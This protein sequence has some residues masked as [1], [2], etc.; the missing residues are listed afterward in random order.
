MLPCLL[1]EEDSRFDSLTQS[2]TLFQ[3]VQMSSDDIQQFTFQ[4]VPQSPNNNNFIDLIASMWAQSMAHFHIKTDDNH[5][6][7]TKVESGLE[8]FINCTCSL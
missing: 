3:Y 8:L 5:N 6:E 7:N 2:K 1:N 4:G